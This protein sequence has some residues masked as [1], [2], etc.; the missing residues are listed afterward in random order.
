MSGPGAYDRHKAVVEAIMRSYGW[1]SDQTAWERLQRLKLVVFEHP[2]IPYHWRIGT[3]EAQLATLQQTPFMR[4][5][6]SIV[7]LADGRRAWF[8]V[9]NLHQTED[10]TE[11]SWPWLE[12]AA[13]A[14]QKMD[15][16][17]EVDDL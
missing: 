1:E 11:A 17:E 16:A 13:E 14:L 5:R 3:D 8:Q 10:T 4:E 7:E 12:R 9:K 6:L 15:E 2:T